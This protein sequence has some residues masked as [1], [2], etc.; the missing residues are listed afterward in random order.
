MTAGT[1]RRTCI[2]QLTR[3]EFIITPLLATLL[4]GTAD[5][6][7]RLT[8][9]RGRA[10]ADLALDEMQRTAALLGRRVSLEDTGDAIVIDLDDGRLEENGASL[11]VVGHRDAKKRAL[12]GWRRKHGTSGHDAVE[13]HPK[14]TRYGAEQLNDRFFRRFRV[15]MDSHAWVGWM[16]VKVAVEA[17]LRAVT[18]RGGLFDGHKGMALRFGSDGYLIQPLCIVSAAG[19]LLGVA[20]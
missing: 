7:L 19:D 5:I 2:R 4:H 9:E 6:R 10:G 16:L 11:F 15:A 3:R 20:E 1:S 8:G 12:D 13:W 18:V 14:L 17:T